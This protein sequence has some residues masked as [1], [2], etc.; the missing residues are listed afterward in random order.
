METQNS[1]L[2]F[3]SNGKL[4]IPALIKQDLDRAKNPN[5]SAVFEF[6]SDEQVS[7]VAETAN[8]SKLTDKQKYIRSLFARR[9]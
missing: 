8:R 7:V 6:E 4:I 2:Q 5:N 9:N 1:R 3:D